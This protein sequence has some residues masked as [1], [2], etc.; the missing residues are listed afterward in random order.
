MI[1]LLVFLAATVGI[2]LLNV[3]LPKLIYTPAF[4]KKQQKLKELM[5]KIYEG[6]VS[7]SEVERALELYTST[8]KNDIIASIIPLAVLSL[9]IY[10]LSKYLKDFTI[11]KIQW[12]YWMI[13]I[14]I[15]LSMFLMKKIYKKN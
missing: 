13:I 12:Y 2:T 3:S 11:L 14:S 1:K 6:E 4:S 9:V 15:P 8:R 7:D 10:P 5:K